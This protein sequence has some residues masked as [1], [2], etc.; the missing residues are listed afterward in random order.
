MSVKR[1]LT[2]RQGAGGGVRRVIGVTAL[3]AA[4][5]GFLA[6]GSAVGQDGGA[7]AAPVA[8]EVPGYA[9]ETFDYPQA[10]R[11]LQE[12]GILL[13]RGDGHI[14]LVDCDSGDNPLQVW[15][16]DHSAPFCFRVTGDEG[17]LALEMPAVYG[18]RGNDYQAQVDMAV[19]GEERTF[20]ITE[21]TWTPVGETADPESGP[22]TLVEIR[23]SR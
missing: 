3:A 1:L 8:D 15:A 6:V 11:I 16:T 10:D 21:N 19:D 17:Y 20:D 9:V 4:V 13:K 18:V 5:A 7:V 14:V 23:T 22:H 2:K 12:R